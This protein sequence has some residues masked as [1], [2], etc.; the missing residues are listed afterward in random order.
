MRTTI[1]LIIFMFFASTA[2]ARN[3]QTTIQIIMDDSGVLIEPSEADKYKMHMLVELKKLTRKRKFSRAHI[4]VISTSIGR[5]IWSGTPSDLKRK[6]VHAL[7]LVNSIKS[8]KENCNNLIGA[9]NE[10]ASAHP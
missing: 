9:F 10:L 6:P 2:I 1:I 7:A 8:V 4:D 5:T 3:T